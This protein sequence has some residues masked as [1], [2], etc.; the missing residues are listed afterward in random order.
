MH[1]SG[2]RIDVAQLAQLVEWAHPM[3]VTCHKV[4]D[5]TP[6]AAH[7]LEDVISTGCHRILTSGLQKTALD[8]ISILSSLITQAAGRIIIMPGGGVRSSNIARLISETGAAEYHS[9]G[10]TPAAADYIADEKEVKLMVDI[11][12]D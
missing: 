1:L 11:L 7:A 10:L 9:S 12:N 2:G 5:R 8:G 3:A 6:D 4:F